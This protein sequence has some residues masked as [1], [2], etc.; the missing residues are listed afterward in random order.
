MTEPLKYTLTVDQG[1]A[2][3]TIKSLLQSK[4]K[5]STRLL[6]QL[7][8]QGIV[9]RNGEPT[10]LNERASEG[11]I[12]NIMLP[13]ETSDIVPVPMDLDIRYEDEEILVVNKPAGVLSHPTA[14]E[15][16]GSIQSGTR[17]YL[18]KEGRVPHA[19]HRLDRDT[20]GLLMFAKHAHV[21][22]LYDDALRRGLLHRVYM[23]I[24]EIGEDADHKGLITRDTWHTVQLP[25]AEDPTKPSRRVVDESGQPARTDYRVLS[26]LPL[27]IHGHATRQ[28]KAVALLQ[29]VLWTGRTH[30]IRLHMS[31]IGLPL[32]GDPDYP[33]RA[34]DGTETSG[35]SPLKR[36]ALHAI[37]LG[38]EHPLTGHPHVVSAPPP[39]DLRSVWR[40]AGGAD[41]DFSLLLTDTAALH[42]V[43]IL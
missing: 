11:D 2:G 4:L 41:S 3:R 10:R 13:I 12:I 28:P 38:W 1:G 35:W 43:R 33:R 23:A 5:V 14:R 29:L 19:V 42:H 37:Q 9:T 22:H 25:I 31:T 21:H 36:Q 6:R 18:A 17:A 20:S 24:V 40:R 39:P 27:P 34:G 15:R 32:V 8:G 30:Q 26:L 7:P 16:L